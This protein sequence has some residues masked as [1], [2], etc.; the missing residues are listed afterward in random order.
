MIGVGIVIAAAIMVV[1][2][3]LQWELRPQTDDATVRANFVGIA[4]QVNGHIV[5]LHVRDNQKVNQGDVLFVIDPRPY[6]IALEKARATLALTRTEVNGLK[7][8]AAT[9]V[10]GISKAEATLNASAANVTSRETD[11]I[12]ADAE[13]ARL[14]AQFQHADEHLKRVEP[15][16][17][18]QFV[19]TDKVEEARTQRS[20]ALEALNEAKAKKRAAVA[21]LAAARAQHIATDA[22]LRQARTDSA[23]AQDAIGQTAD[24]INARIAAAEA[25]VHSAELD[26]SY[27]TVRA[28]FTALV[29]NMNISTGAFARAGAEVFTLVDTSTWYVIA[30]F[31]ETQLRHIAAGA[32]VDLYL[33]SHPGKHFRGSVVGLGWAVLPENGTSVGG[34]PR[35]ER[36]LDWIRLAARFPVRIKVDSP[37]DSF[38]LGAS[39]VATVSGNFSAAER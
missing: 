10:A 28:P 39:A 30:N 8:G 2:T 19:T 15:L 16:L 18:Q 14:E 38:R 17:A 25:A 13:I 3:L 1:V 6:E 24:G 31:R 27:C 29:V 23:R 26:L 35:V 22:A 33:Q 37:D 7:N 9:A 20:A 21:A 5:E 4:P 11:P 36:S 34:L 12:V 32:P